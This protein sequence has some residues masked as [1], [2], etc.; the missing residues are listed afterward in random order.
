MVFPGYSGLTSVML[1]CILLAVSGHVAESLQTTAPDVYVTSDGGY[2]W[3][4]V[5]KMQYF[6]LMANTIYKI[7]QKKKKKK[8]IETM[9]HWYSSESTQ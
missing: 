8:I 6:I 9:A 1:T 7:L 5:W 4:K 2:T 3:I